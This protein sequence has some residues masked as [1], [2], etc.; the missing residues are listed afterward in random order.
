MH[1][2]QKLII[3]GI[4]LSL[5]PQA[6][7]ANKIFISN[8]SAILLEVYTSQGC[9]SC[10]PAEKWM[11]K[12]VDSPDL[13]EKIIPVNLHVDYWDYLGWKDP[14]A[15][16]AFSQRQRRFNQLGLTQ[17]VA[18]PGFIV[19][20]KGWNGWFYRESVPYSNIANDKLTVMLENQ[21]LQIDFDS[22]KEK[23]LYA[24]I[25]I[26]GFGIETPIKRGENKDKNL[27]HDFIVTGFKQ[28]RMKNNKKLL[29]ALTELPKARVNNSKK[30]AIVVW[31]STRLD[32]SPIQV[33]GGWL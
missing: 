9:S 12:F 31:L 14:F 22:F 7:A 28:V 33:V 20:G 27:K 18:T 32:P 15:F 10:P 30:S 2:F 21:N 23:N 17:N 6:S 24:N 3:I 25:A 26:L 16:K 11:S 8:N 1:Q 19:N 29:S 5:M 4:F 13:W